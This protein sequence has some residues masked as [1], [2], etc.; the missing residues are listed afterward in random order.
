[1]IVVIHDPTIGSHLA[2]WVAGPV[3]REVADRVY[4]N[5]LEMNQSAPMHFVGNTQ[6][7]K[8]KAGNR[9]AIQQV[10]SKLNIKPLYAS[11]NSA[12]SGVD[13]SSGLPYQEVKYAKG[14]VP[15]VTGMGL[16]DALYVLGNAGYKV[17]VHGS[18]TVV[19]Q[20]VTGGSVI[21][22]GSKITIELQ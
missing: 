1:M 14:S 7:P 5:D 21:P 13:T 16:S 12:A 2:A 8:A 10:Y 18:G 9:K 20:S 3:F 15:E 19:K 11:T 6:L 4:S 17:G 22:K